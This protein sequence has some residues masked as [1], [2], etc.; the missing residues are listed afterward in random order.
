MLFQWNNGLGPGVANVVDTMLFVFGG[1]TEFDVLFM[2]KKYPL[3][4]RYNKNALKFPQEV[5]SD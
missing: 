2:G 4:T 5:H 3:P 1:L